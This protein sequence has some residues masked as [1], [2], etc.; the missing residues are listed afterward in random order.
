M[1]KNY[2][3]Y[4]LEKIRKDYNLIADDFSNTRNFISEDIIILSK[5]TK[6]GDKVLD[7]GC[8]NGRLSEAFEGTDRY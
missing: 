2:A 8:G 7:L 3:K 6:E 4:L 1:D 5:Y